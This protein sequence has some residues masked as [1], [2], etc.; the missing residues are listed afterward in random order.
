MTELEN[1]KYVFFWHGYLSQWY[2]L[3]MIIDNINFVCA[4][5]YMMYSKAILFNDKDIANK[6]LVTNNPKIMKQLGRQ[7][8]NFNDIV[9][10]K[11]R[12]SIV[13]KGNVAKFS[14]NKV[15]KNKLL[16]TKNKTLV[17]ASPY[18]LL[19]GVG[20]N[21]QVASKTDESKWPGLNLLGK[22]LMQ[23]RETIKD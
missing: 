14:Q 8:K 16:A 20:L 23:V 9:W 12:E 7:I 10:N 19:Y 1:D 6:I 15:L 4:E 2:M 18:D 3:P 5:Q 17:E 13:Y 11:N 21:A 22:I